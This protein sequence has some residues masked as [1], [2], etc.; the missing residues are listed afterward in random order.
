LFTRFKDLNIFPLLLSVVDRWE[1]SVQPWFELL[2][3][4]VKTELVII[5]EKIARQQDSTKRA[6]ASEAN[7]VQKLQNRVRS[8]NVD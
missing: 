3:G 6:A 4:K 5:Q 2:E 1:S 7:K 8:S